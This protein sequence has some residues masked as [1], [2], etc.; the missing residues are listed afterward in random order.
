LKIISVALAIMLISSAYILPQGIDLRDTTNQYDYIIIT[1]PEF[2]QAC[3]AFKQH[4]EDIRHFSVLLVDTTQIYN[5]FNSDTTGEDNIRDFISYAGT[6]WRNPKPKYILLVGNRSKIPSFPMYNIYLLWTDFY[7][8]QNIYDQNTDDKDFEVGRVPAQTQQEIYNYFNKVINY[9]AS[10]DSILSNNAILWAQH[11]VQFGFEEAA[12]TL[13]DQFPENINFTIFSSDT[14][15]MNFGNKDSVI[16][17]VNNSGISTLWLIGHTYNDSFIS[18]DFFNINDIS[19]LT[20]QSNYF[21][22]VLFSQYQSDDSTTNMQ[23][24]MLLSSAAAL[25]G[26]AVTGPTWWPTIMSH[27]YAMQRQLYSS[28]HNSFGSVLD[29]DYIYYHDDTSMLLNIWGDPS[30]ILR[31]STVTSVKQENQSANL[32]Y[33]LEQNYPNPFNPVTT[34][35]YELPARS[36]MTLKIY[37]LLG[38]VVKTLISGIENSGK[39]QVKFDAANLPSGVYFYRIEAGNFVQTKKLIL[40]K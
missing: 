6:Y 19:S 9:E 26:I 35:E 20:N 23:D 16:N 31:Y 13:A 4:K 40:L 33:A 14:S 8:T 39:H 28:T 5:Q 27:Y 10:E 24:E 18:N 21:I 22:S 37:N 32:N 3:Q 17:H 1:V 25:G 15:E 34:I 38:Q 7:Y 11:D 29:S 30:L 36:F 2:V 12:G